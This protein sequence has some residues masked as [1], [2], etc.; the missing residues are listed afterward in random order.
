MLSGFLLL[1][2]ELQML[3]TGHYPACIAQ[4]LLRRASLQV[5]P[6]MHDCHGRYTN[7]LVQSFRQISMRLCNVLIGPTQSA[8][9]GILADH[10]LSR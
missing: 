6:T 1:S 2:S 7:D 8:S 3:T 4:Q 9:T 10:N 5:I